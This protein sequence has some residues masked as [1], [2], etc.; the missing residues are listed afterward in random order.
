MI[1]LGI[2][3]PWQIGL[4]LIA[5]L[6][7]PFFALIDIVK[8]EFKNNDKLMWILIVIFFNFLGS[9]IYFM[10]GKNQKINE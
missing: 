2:I 10:I 7:I 8:S 3:G 1:N 9:L 6:L 5:I 4:I